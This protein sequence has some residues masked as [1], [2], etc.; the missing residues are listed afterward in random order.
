MY[1]KDFLNPIHLN[2]NRTDWGL[3]LVNYYLTVEILRDV[4]NLGLQLPTDFEFWHLVA[5]Y[6]LRSDHEIFLLRVYKLL[7][8]ITTL[9]RYLHVEWERLLDQIRVIGE[10]DCYLDIVRD[11]NIDANISLRIFRL[12]FRQLE[13][14]SYL[15][16]LIPTH[17]LQKLTMSY[18]SQVLQ[19]PF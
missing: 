3:G 19:V 13:P 16:L 14:E 9:L 5:F 1:G 11:G 17:K 18:F 8:C 10:L 4:T 6:I 12:T 2:V 15:T 7:D